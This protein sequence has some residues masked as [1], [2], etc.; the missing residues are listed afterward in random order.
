MVPHSFGFALLVSLAG[1][2]PNPIPAA[3]VW[4]RQDQVGIQADS[5]L[6]HRWITSVGNLGESYLAGQGAGHEIKASD[7]IELNT[8]CSQFSWSIPVLLNS[9]GMLGDNSARKIQ[10]LAC[11]G[12]K[13]G[14]VLEKQIPK[15]RP[16]QLILIS[17]GG[18]DAH[19]VNILNY[20]VYQWS[21]TLTWSCDKELDAA[22]KDIESQ[23]FFDNLNKVMDQSKAKL[24]DKNSRIIWTGYERFFNADTTDCD[25]VTW[26]FSFKIGFREF[27][28]QA[29]R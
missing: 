24:L 1:A 22:R 16:S 8:D 5:A 11:T 13:T 14:D 20:C 23:D 21:V 17:I 25:K 19:L 15:L 2:V 9:R 26:G 18:N 6:D 10:H 12:A 7:Q 28:T 29:R 4:S 3:A 27:L